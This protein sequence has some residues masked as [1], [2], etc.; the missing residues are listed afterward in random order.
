MSLRMEISGVFFC[1]LALFQSASASVYS[2]GQSFNYAIPS[3]YSQYGSDGKG[4]MRAA[5]I[6]IGSHHILKDLD[7]HL[8]ITHQHLA[9]L[10][11][12]I[13]SPQGTRIAL[14]S[15]GNP[16][17][18]AGG[19][20]IFIF[21]QQASLAADTFSS[22]GAVT[23]LKPAGVY[24]LDSFNGQDAFGAWTINIDDKYFSNT[25]SLD[26]V[27]MVVTNPE[28]ATALLMLTGMVLARRKK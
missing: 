7:I 12:T 1:V 9:D 24:S 5:V 10:D 22:F 18:T 11:I 6:N 26:F 14:F 28:P 8:G 16:A 21:D 15:S 2:F 3:P 20:L 17:L 27:R 19:K 25:G 13:T 4:A 23:T